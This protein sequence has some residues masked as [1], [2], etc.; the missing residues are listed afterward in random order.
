LTTSFQPIV[1]VVFATD[2]SNDFLYQHTGNNLI[3][4]LPAEILVTVVVSVLDEYEEVMKS[5]KRWYCK[6]VEN[7][8]H[9]PDLEQY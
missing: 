4:S 7:K 9:R 3:K 2:C 6:G 5:K 1:T 8:I